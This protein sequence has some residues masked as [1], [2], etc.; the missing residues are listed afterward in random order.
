MMI[1]LDYIVGCKVGVEVDWDLHL[2]VCDLMFVRLI[3]DW[4]I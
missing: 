3:F 2:V 1:I 4:S